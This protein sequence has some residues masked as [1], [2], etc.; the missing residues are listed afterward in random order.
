M[1]ALLAREVWHWPRWTVAAVVGTFMIIDGA[2]FASNLTKIPDGGWF[3]LTVA[4][5]TFTLLTTWARGRALMRARLHE[6]A[7]PLGVFA[8]SA[9]SSATPVAGTAVFMTASAEGVPPALLHN[10]KHNKVLHARNI[11]LTVTIDDVPYIDPASRTEITQLEPEFWRIELHYGFM[12]EVDV[13][14]DLKR[15]EGCGPGFKMADTSFYLGRQT[16]IPAA[17]PGMPLWRELLFAAMM[18]NAETA[19]EFFKLPSN[20]VVELGS[21]VEI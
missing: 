3:P 10:L 11:L 1:L 20:R 15:V 7:M 18:R 8:K 6:S 12:Q 14:A 5:I 9:R 13:P 21:Q 16:L 17:R 2:Y 4:A 19:M